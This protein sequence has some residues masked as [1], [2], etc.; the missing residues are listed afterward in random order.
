MPI[1]FSKAL[2]EIFMPRARLDAALAALLS[3]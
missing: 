2:E 1:P 3:Y